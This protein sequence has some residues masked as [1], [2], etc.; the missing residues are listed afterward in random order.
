MNTD[1][2]ESPN[3]AAVS[4]ALEER[5]VPVWGGKVTLRVKVFGTGADVVYLHP[6]AGL[7]IDDFLMDLA[8]T[9][10][11]FAI[12]FPGTSADDPYAVRQFDDLHDVVLAYEE[13]IRQLGI[14]RPIVIGQ[15]F[16]GMLAAELA[17][18]FPALFRRAVLLDPIGLWRDDMPVV[19]WNSVPAEQ[20]P[21]LLFADPDSE[22]ARAFLAMPTD[23]ESFVKTLAARVWTLGCTGSFVW[24]IPDRGL[25][26]RLH[27][28]QIPTKIIWGRDDQL[29]SSGYAVEFQRL[30]A[31]SEVEIVDDCG[32]IPQ[33]EK[34]VET[35]RIVSGFLAQAK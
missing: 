29:V 26:K 4:V 32:H 33:V 1:T 10:R 12:E 19:H 17:S 15:S 20:M 9:H 7:V 2:I 23:Q 5:K 31:D 28:I 16:G 8:G 25:A 34:R 30:I 21:S 13:A 11:I 35:Y 24:P 6:A 22:A 27:R 14:E 18:T 3:Q